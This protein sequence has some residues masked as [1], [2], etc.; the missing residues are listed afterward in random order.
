M[1]STQQ[2]KELRDKTGAGVSDIKKALEQSGGDSIKAR[3]LIEEELGSAA[4]KRAG[5]E[6]GAGVVEAYIHSNARIGALVELW[7]ETDFVA[8]NPAFKALAH[9]I[10]MQIG[11]MAP[12]DAAALAR[13]AFIKDEGKTV[14]DVVNEAIG[15]FGENIKI[16][17]FARFEL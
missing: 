12:A 14:G 11:A 10:V 15:R 16:G 7:C 2:I 9:E 8:R 13:Q 4:G 5:R 6:T 17:N 3:A 1:I